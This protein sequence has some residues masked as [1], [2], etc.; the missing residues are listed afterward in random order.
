MFHGS[1]RITER[2]IR[3]VRESTYERVGP[4]FDRDRQKKRRHLY[5]FFVV[6]LWP[7]WPGLTAHKFR[8]LFCNV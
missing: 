1:K 4:V 3:R 2:G 5:L 8:S 7:V 6:E